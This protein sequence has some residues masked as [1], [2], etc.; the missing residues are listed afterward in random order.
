MEVS[1][2]KS[3][4]GEACEAK[5]LLEQAADRMEN[6]KRENVKRENARRENVKR[7]DGS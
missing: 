6:A 5:Q 7:G 3:D 1:V 2:G 4:S